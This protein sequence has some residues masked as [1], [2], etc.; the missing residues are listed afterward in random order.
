M[1]GQFCLFFLFLPSEKKVRN[2]QRRLLR[3]GCRVDINTSTSLCVRGVGGWEGAGSRQRKF[4][5][6]RGK[7]AETA[8]SQKCGRVKVKINFLHFFAVAKEKQVGDKKT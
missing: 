5:N 7:I 6:N 1:S 2:L 4:L 8:R 3:M